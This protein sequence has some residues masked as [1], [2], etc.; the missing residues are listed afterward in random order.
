M[1]SI[2]EVTRELRDRLRTAKTDTQND[3][4]LRRLA[5]R[6]RPRRAAKRRPLALPPP[7]DAPVS[8]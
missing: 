8:R 1:G 5:S 7:A 2:A 4:W 3:D 6:P